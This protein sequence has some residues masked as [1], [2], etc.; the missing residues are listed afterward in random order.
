MDRMALT[1]GHLSK[2]ED[3]DDNTQD[4]GITSQ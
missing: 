2:E 3:N 1:G 4:L